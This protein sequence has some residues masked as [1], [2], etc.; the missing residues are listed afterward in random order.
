LVYYKS[1]ERRYLLTNLE[2]FRVL[3]WADCLGRVTAR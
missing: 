1:E 3:V 2:R